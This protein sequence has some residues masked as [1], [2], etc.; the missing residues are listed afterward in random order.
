M[1]TRSYSADVDSGV[2]SRAEPEFELADEEWSLIS[3]L[4]DDPSPS[5]LGGCRRAS[6]RACFE[7][8]AWVLRTGARWRDS[9]VRILSYLTWHSSFVINDHTRK[10]PTVPLAGQ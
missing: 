10:P 1:P 5:P 4:F 8:I 9:P 3:D 2:G 7:A 6:S